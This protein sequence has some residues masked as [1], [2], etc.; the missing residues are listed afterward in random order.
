MQFLIIPKRA[1]SE[2]NEWVISTLRVCC[3]RLAVKLG[4]AG[5]KRRWSWELWARE[6]GGQLLWL[7]AQIRSY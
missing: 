1:N 5:L 3:K 7:H 4:T 6:R 2:D